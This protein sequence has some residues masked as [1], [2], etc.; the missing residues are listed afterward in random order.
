MA[1]ALQYLFLFFTFGIPIY[2]CAAVFQ[3][4]KC[5]PDEHVPCFDL[6]VVAKIAKNVSKDMIAAD[7]ENIL[8]KHNSFDKIRKKKE[9]HSCVLHKI[10]DLFQDVLVE[11]ERRLFEQHR[12]ETNHLE[13]IY[14][15]DQLRNCVYKVKKGCDNLYQKADTMA[16]LKVLKNLKPKQVAI[17]QLQKLKYASERLEDVNIQNRAMD[18]LKLL[19][20]Y[21]HGKGFR[22][23]RND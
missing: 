14:I 22:E 8:L 18:E 9:L 15:M 2:E 5:V 10:I 11:T 1:N 20:F 17:L 13:L 19:H 4:A 12:G 16:D 3:D 6:S 23:N 7:G 21:M